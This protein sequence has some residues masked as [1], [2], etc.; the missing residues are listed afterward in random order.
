[1]AATLKLQDFTVNFISHLAS[2][3]NVL[4]VANGETKVIAVSNMEPKSIHEHLIALRNDNGDVS[5]KF[6]EKTIFKGVPVR[7]PWNAWHEILFSP[8]DGSYQAWKESCRQL[9]QLRA[10]KRKELQAESFKPYE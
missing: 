4:V 2:V 7:Q 9:D 1:L 8:F 10:K 3:V 6:T 5:A